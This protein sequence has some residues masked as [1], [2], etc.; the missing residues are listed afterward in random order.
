MTL[1]GVIT[2]VLPVF[3]LYGCNDMSKKAGEECRVDADC[4]DGLSCF[5]E[6]MG[7]PKRLLCYDMR[8]SVEA[9]LDKYRYYRNRMCECANSSEA[10]SCLN[11]IS[12]EE[13][14]D[15]RV[16]VAANSEQIAQMAKL[17]SEAKA[18]LKRASK[19]GAHE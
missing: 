6:K 4:R 2:V 7:T 14:E 8:P 5:S 11:G 17:F 18:C 16:S 12:L 13:E 10:P 1:R 15:E 3:L 9:W 19:A